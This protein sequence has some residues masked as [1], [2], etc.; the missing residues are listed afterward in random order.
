MDEVISSPDPLNDSPT[1]QS[2][3]KPRRSSR[4]RHSLPLQASSPN[5]QI[6][7]L[8]VG[9][10]ISPQKIRVTVEAGDDNAYTYFG[11]GASRYPSPSKARTNRRR[12][13]TTTTT[14]TIPVKGLSDSEGEAAQAV[15]PKRARGRPRKSTGTPIAKGKGRAGTPTQKSRRKSIGDLVDGDDEDDVNFQVGKNV[16]VGRGKGRSRSR[17]VTVKGSRKP[18]SVVK[19]TDTLTKRSASRKGGWRGKA[20]AAAFDVHEDESCAG[21]AQGC[22]EMEDAGL[23]DLLDTIDANSVHPESQFSTMRSTTTLGGN[24]S[25]IVIARFNPEEETPR[26]AGWSSPHTN[27]TQPSN[28]RSR[29]DSY[30]SPTISPAKSTISSYVEESMAVMPL[31]ES[32]DED[33]AGDNRQVYEED[34]INEDDGEGDA[35]YQEFDTMLESEGFSMISVDSLPSLREH[36]SS[37]AN[38]PDRQ[39]AQHLLNKKLKSLR[40][41]EASVHNDS[42]SS[43]PEEVL[44]AA[45]PGRRVENSRLLSVQKSRVDDSFSSI[46]PALLEAATPA[47]AKPVSILLSRTSQVDDSFSSVAPEILEAA[48]PGRPVPKARPSASTIKNEFYEDSFSAITPAVL[49]TATPAAARQPHPTSSRLDIPGQRP[50]SSRSQAKSPTPRLLTPDETPSPPGEAS[51][52]QTLSSAGNAA[53]SKSSD[54]AVEDTTTEASNHDSLLMQSYLPSSPPSLMPRRFT[55]TAHLRQNRQLN[56]AVVQTPSI[57]FSSPALPPRVQVGRGVITLAPPLDPNNRPLLSPVVR[58]GQSLQSIIVPSSPRSRSQSLGSPFKSPAANRTSSS[59]GQQSYPSPIHERF[60]GPLPRLDLSEQLSGTSS[61][62]SQTRSSPPEDPFRNDALVQQRSPSPEEREQYALEVPERKRY[63]DSRITNLRSEVNSVRSEDAMSWQAEEE[64]SVPEGNNGNSSD[65]MTA[66]QRWAAERATVSQQI[67]N[68]NRSDVIVIDSDDE[69]SNPGEIEDDDDDFGLLL[70]T[71]NSSSPAVQREEPP[72]DIAERPRRSKIPSPWR[73]NSKRLTYSDELHLSSS[74]MEAKIVDARTFGR[75]VL[76]QPVTVRRV[77]PRESS[78]VV[79][80]DLSGWQIP[81]KSNFQPRVRESG[82]M[83]LSALLAASPPKRLPILPLRSQQPSSR[84][85]SSSSQASIDPPAQNKN[86]WPSELL[87]NRGN[88]ISEFAPIP[89]KMGFAPRARTDLS[90]PI[91]QPSQTHDIF[92]FHDKENETSK[93]LEQRS[94]TPPSHSLS[95]SSPSRT[96][97]LSRDQTPSAQVSPSSEQSSSVLSNEPDRTTTSRTL[98]WTESL[99]PNPQIAAIVYNPPL[100]PSLPSPTKSCLRSP[101]KTPLPSTSPSKGVKFVSSSPCPSPI[102]APLSSTTW[103]KEHWLLLGSIL[104]NW[105]PSSSS[106]GEVRRRRNSTRVISRL[107]GKNVSSDGAKMRL[108]QWH[109]EA[110]DEFRGVVPGW[111]EKVIAMRVFALV[112]GEERRAEERERGGEGGKRVWGFGE[113]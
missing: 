110:V 27:Q 69:A 70:E 59:A 1:Y 77:M 41:V 23:D 20:G 44:Q 9:N 55:Y 109:L 85:D 92:T 16:E 7:E 89:Q 104:Q 73:K 62:R 10:K 65:D 108:E 81:Q 35:G 21:D 102:T 37:P 14:T 96:N 52:A 95:A 51:I 83:D 32:E 49:D 93:E 47:R 19:E 105:K 84:V 53:T 90:L 87:Q 54:Q 97:S 17:S 94:S 103:S 60:A 74:P 18:A 5:K 26:R 107:L 39:P 38:P 63:S 46:P 111:Q 79:D 28:S 8:D 58:A 86:I 67:S 3:A 99:Q 30:P 68:A 88:K 71:L 11:H 4:A 36:L 75:D 101:L 50:S 82:N 43:I 98:A 25:D 78:D 24:E 72:K 40:G 66:E 42:F 45:T 13:R 64:I 91:K 15:T 113:E 112:V 80:A 31:L 29:A 61:Q 2:P 6:F 100:Y 56:P 76:S 106:S 57:V 22:D 33:I 12:E 48:T 34:Q